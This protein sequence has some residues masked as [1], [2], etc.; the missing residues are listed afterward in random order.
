MYEVQYC[1]NIHDC[2]EVPT[3]PIQQG[4]KILRWE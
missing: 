3:Y 4:T 2:A 1:E